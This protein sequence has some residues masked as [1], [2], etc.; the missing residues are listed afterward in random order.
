MPANPDHPTPFH[1]RDDGW[2]G[3]SLTLKRPLVIQPDKPLRL[4]YGLWAHPGIPTREEVEARWGG[5][6]RQPAWPRDAK[7]G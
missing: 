5:F 6:V 7:Q 2:M 4:R 3:A 1:V